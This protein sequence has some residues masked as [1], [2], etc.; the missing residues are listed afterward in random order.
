ML[1]VSQTAVFKFAA[2]V[3]RCAVF[4]SAFIAIPG[5]NTNI[6]ASKTNYG[7]LSSRDLVACSFREV[8]T[9]RRYKEGR[10]VESR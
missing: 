5:K 1:F 2:S 7:S 3:F 10:E 4:L 9:G 6:A 8:Y